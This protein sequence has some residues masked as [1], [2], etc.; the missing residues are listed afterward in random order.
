MNS[1]PL[2]SLLGIPVFLPQARQE[3]TD[4]A[5]LSPAAQALIVDAA[6][7]VY[8]TK[9]PEDIPESVREEIA[10]WAAHNPEDEHEPG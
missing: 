7:G 8:D 3:D 1:T 4:F 9:P 10:K 5:R 6:L 2:T